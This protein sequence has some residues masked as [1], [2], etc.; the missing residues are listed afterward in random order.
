M[1]KKVYKIFSFVLSSLII[2]SS[3]S[4][5]VNATVGAFAGPI[6]QTIG[7]SALGTTT[8]TIVGNLLDSWLGTDKRY[9]DCQGTDSNMN[10]YANSSNFGT[11][12]SSGA[13]NENCWNT[14]NTNITDKRTYSLVKN[15][16]NNT[17]S[18]YCPITNTYKTINNVSN[19]TYNQQ[20]DTYYIQNNE[21]NYYVTN[22][23][24]Y[25][26]YYIINNSTN[27][28][29]YYEIYYELPDGRNSYDLRPYEVWGEYFVYDVVGYDSI[30]EDDGRTLAL[31][32]LNQD[33][34]DSSYWNHSDIC[35]GLGVYSTGKFDY[36]YAV[37]FQNRASLILPS[38]FDYNNFTLEFTCVFPSKE[39]L[40]IKIPSEI[41]PNSID[42]DYAYFKLGYSPSSGGIYSVVIQSDNGSFSFYLNGIK[43][44]DVEEIKE[45]EY[46]YSYI[47]E[48]KN[49]CLI[50]GG[51]PNKSNENFLIDEIRLSNCPLYSSDSISVMS[52]EFDT[53]QV[54]CTPVNFH[55]GIIAIK[56]TYKVS[57]YRV[58]GVRPTYPTEGFVYIYLEN[59]ICKGIQQ[60]QND[61]WYS[62]DGCIRKKGEWITLEDYDFSVLSFDDTDNDS[63]NSGNNGSVSDN[64]TSSGDSGDSGGSSGGGLGNFLKGLGSIGD[65]LLSILG[66]LLEYVGKA[67]ELITGLIDDVLTIIPE[68]ITN[69]ISAL[70]PFIPEEWVSCITLSLVLGVVGIIIGLFKK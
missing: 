70:F 21:Y 53:N 4:V 3:F 13:D 20:Y 60:F 55:E 23:Y 32:H 64:D 22:N 54:L 2:L 63:S 10:Y 12:S 19:I 52:Q 58:G 69:L 47:L 43:I 46:S 33:L 62:V 66:K 9:Y 44:T 15:T 34:K 16:T 26:S 29:S 17:T 8:A 51:N 30:V 25:V 57:D 56:G 31:Y 65:A 5:P 6:L 67:F 38:N 41:Y 24:T 14:Y 49:D 40:Y 39:N 45:L 7:Y 48:L 35:G 59:N 28:E 27:E 61:G 36:G 11:I 68:N 50:F 18:I 1:K 42:S 37:N